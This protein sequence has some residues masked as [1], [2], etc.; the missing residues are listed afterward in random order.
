MKPRTFRS[1]ADWRAWLERH[2]ADAAELVVRC[3]KVRAR[4]RGLTYPEAVDEALCY[5]W[6]DGVRRTGD[7]ESFTVRFTPR[8]PRSVWSAINLRRATQLAAEGRMQP[9]GQAAFAARHQAASR[10]YSYENR[11]TELPPEY[12]AR[13]RANPR[14]WAF[15][16]DQPP[17]Y[18]RT[19]SFW[20]MEAKREE[21]R[22]RRLQTL[23]ECSAE[24]RTIP[25]L[26]RRPA[27]G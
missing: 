10:T 9:A 2:H 25:P 16:Q 8:R 5:G 21:T 4:D 6:I 11:P 14:A 22:L 1:A 7:A 19:S 26:T 17:W 18:R 23:L 15:F 24:G 12:T 27:D 13:I 20:V 3:W